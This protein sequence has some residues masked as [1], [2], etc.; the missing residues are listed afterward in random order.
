[1]KKN[2]LFS[3]ALLTIVGLG[4]M[5]SQTRAALTY[6]AGDLFIGFH[7]PGETQDYVVNIG[8][9]SS[10][11]H[12][13]TLS[14]NGIDADLTAVFGANWDTR[15]DLYW[16]VFGGDNNIHG[17]SGSPFQSLYISRA[18]TTLGT[19]ATPFIRGLS[20]TQGTVG[21]SMNNVA[22]F[23]TL[24]TVS[25]NNPV[26]SI[27]NTT[28]TNSYA[29]TQDVSGTK[30]FTSGA[31]FVGSGANTF[32]GGAA[33][34]AADLFFLAP[35]TASNQPADYKGTFKISDTGAI[36]FT[37]APVPVPEPSTYGLI[38][39]AGIVLLIVARRSR[40]TVQA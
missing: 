23:F 13:F 7:A 2:S 34:S 8:Q 40:K 3:T 4:L 22:T 39:G 37:T 5:A 32:A 17:D 6:N 30:R 11:D 20:G 33:N 25:A 12:D 16:T 19:Q 29:S 35:R 14:I 15:A 1:M 18:E 31:S 26:G 10:F 36:S 27:Q 28:D 24:G 9:A 38:L 21:T